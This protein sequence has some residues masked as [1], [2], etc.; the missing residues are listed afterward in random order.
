MHRWPVVRRH[1]M[2]NVPRSLERPDQHA[3]ASPM[4]ED[5]S[6]SPPHAHPEPSPMKIVRVDTFTHWIEWCNWL[7]VRIE[8]DDGLHGWGEGSLH[9]SIPAVEAAI[10]ELAG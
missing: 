6:S 9:G 10:H 4:C 3:I 7:F 2:C 8:T 5:D 1:E